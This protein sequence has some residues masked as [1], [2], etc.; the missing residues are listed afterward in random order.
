MSAGP[1]VDVSA[2]GS[3]AVVCS[4]SGG[5]RRPGVCGKSPKEIAF[6]VDRWAKG[7]CAEPPVAGADSVADLRP[8]GRPPAF[9]V[10]ASKPK[11]RR[12]DSVQ[13]ARNAVW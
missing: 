1:G 9:L 6:A 2:R 12:S 8:R 3:L 5:S 11:P 7:Y 13:S 4:R 10:G